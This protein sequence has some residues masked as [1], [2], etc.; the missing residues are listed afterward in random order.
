M[1]LI[2]ASDLP[3]TRLELR[4]R[5]IEES[6][7]HDDDA[8]PYTVM[9]DYDLVLELDE[10]D[11]RGEVY[12]DAG[13]LTE[14]KREKRVSL[15]GT[16]S[17]GTVERRLNLERGEIDAPFRDGSHALWDHLKLKLPAY[18]VVGEWAM[19]LVQHRQAIALARGETWP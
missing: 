9:C 12:N 3:R 4:W 11:I 6:D 10:L 2:K 19:D 13:E 14:R 15:G 1:A 5:P 17:S 7:R 16:K 8:Y 18:V